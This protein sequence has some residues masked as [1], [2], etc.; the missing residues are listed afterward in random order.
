MKDREGKEL[1]VVSHK[2]HLR[3]QKSKKAVSNHT[4]EE[5]SSKGSD[6]CVFC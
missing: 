2:I 1:R 3:L 6:L 4:K 5:K